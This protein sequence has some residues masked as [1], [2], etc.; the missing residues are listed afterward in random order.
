MQGLGFVSAEKQA[1]GPLEIVSAIGSAVKASQERLPMKDLITNQIFAF[2]KS[3]T[4]K[5]HRIDTA[6]KNLIT[7]LWLSRI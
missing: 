3:V 7:N 1:P 4:S 5:R 2:N 6:R